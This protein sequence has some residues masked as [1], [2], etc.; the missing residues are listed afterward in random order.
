MDLDKTW[1]RG[2]E[3]GKSDLVKFL[4]R[5]LQKPQRRGKIQPFVVNTVHWFGHFR[6]TDVLQKLAGIH[7]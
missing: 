4:V 7:E 3:W 1:Q 2:G 5:S 6:F